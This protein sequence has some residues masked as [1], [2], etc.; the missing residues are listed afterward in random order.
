M[1]QCVGN[2]NK[3]VEEMKLRGPRDFL[4]GLIFVVF[5]VAAAVTARD[6]PMGSAMRMGPG[7]FPFL[8]G[9]LLAAMGLIIM[10]RGLL[11]AGP[12]P[13]ATFWRPIL[14]VLGAIGTFAITVESLGL[15]VATALLVGIGAA[16]SPESRPRETMWLLAG[17]VAFAL[18]VFVFALKLPFKVWPG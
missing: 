8:L 12:S 6:Y 10:A 13:E 14:L 17:L 4:G 7:Y 3:R 9:C 15:A 18:G 2:N 16:A 5:G 1:E 11:H